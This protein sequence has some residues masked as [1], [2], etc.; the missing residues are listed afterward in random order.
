MFNY[1]LKAK[2]FLTKVWT[3]ENILDLFVVDV[4]VN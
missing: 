4:N 3:Y 2:P 1:F